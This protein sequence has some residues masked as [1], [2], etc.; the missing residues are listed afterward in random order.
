MISKKEYE[1]IRLRSDT[2]FYHQARTFMQ[3]I[4][5]TLPPTQVNGLL[6]VAL[7]NTY[8]HLKEFIAHQAERKTW[9]GQEQRYVPDFYRKLTHKLQEI[10]R[11]VPLIALE[12]QKELSQKEREEIST[13]LAREFIQHILAENGY[14]AIQRDQQE[15][16]ERGQHGTYRPDQRRSDERDQGNY[17][18]PATRRRE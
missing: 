15:Q 13:L 9:K 16:L 1:R 6:N 3:S 18:G 7:A 2:E 11:T 4:G 12:R 10:E 17:W 14:Q 5:G 8:Q